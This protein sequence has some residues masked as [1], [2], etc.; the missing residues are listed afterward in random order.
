MKTYSKAIAALIS[1][2]IGALVAFGV[3]GP[4]FAEALSADTVAMLTSTVVTV[5]TVA[6]VWAAPANE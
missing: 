5:L 4:S 6:G 2:I 3:V 1:S